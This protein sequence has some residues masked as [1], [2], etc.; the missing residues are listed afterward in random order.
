MTDNCRKS[1]KSPW[2]SEGGKAEEEGMSRRLLGCVFF[3]VGKKDKMFYFITAARLA[4]AAF[5]R[6]IRTKRRENVV[7]SSF[8]VLV[9]RTNDTEATANVPVIVRQIYL[10]LRNCFC[11]NS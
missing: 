3:V 5:P 7:S 8:L 6:K 1:R 9:F 2:E 4:H 10:W 11:K